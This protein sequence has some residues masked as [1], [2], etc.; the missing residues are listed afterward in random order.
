MKVF[1]VIADSLE[2][3]KKDLMPP[4]PLTYF[5]IQKYYPSKY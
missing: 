4:Q 1:V 2:K 5:E 3:S